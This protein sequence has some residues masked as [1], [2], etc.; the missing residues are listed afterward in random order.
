MVRTKSGKNEVF[1]RKTET[2]VY[3]MSH[4]EEIIPDDVVSIQ[5]FGEA[6][7]LK[8]MRRRISER[9]NIFTYVGNVVLCLNPYMYIPDM[10]RIAEPP[11][12]KQYEYGKDPHVYATA[13]FAYWGLRD[14]DNF[15]ALHAKSRN[16]SCPVSGESGA[17]KTVS[18]GFIMKYLAKLSDWRMAELGLKKD[19]SKPDTTALV[20]GV[21]PF[22]EGFGN[23]KTTM[24]NNSSR[25]GKFTKI[26]FRDGMIKGAEM[27]R[28]L[29]EKGR[30]VEQGVHE[31]NFH[32][33]YGFVK[34]ASAEERKRYKL[35]RVEDYKILMRGNTPTIET[36]SPTYDVDRMNN[37]LSDDPDDTGYRAA[38][39]AAGVG[40]DAQRVLWDCLVA[41]MM[42]GNVNFE[43]DSTR[44]QGMDSSKVSNKKVCDEVERLLGVDDLAEQLVIYRLITQTQTIDKPVSIIGANDNRNALIKALYGHIFQ[45]L[46]VDVASGILKPESKGSEDG[47]IGLLDIFGFE[48]FKRNSME[49]LCINFANEKL[50]KLFND[51][52][53]QT[54]RATYNSQGIPDDCIPPYKDNTPCCHL[55]ERSKDGFMGILPHLNDIRPAETI[56]ENHRKDELYCRDLI[57]MW[58]REPGVNNKCKTKLEKNASKSFFARKNRG[59]KWFVV[60]HFAGDVKYWVDG[61]ITKN[62]DKLPV[63]LDAIMKKSKMAFV[64]NLFR[65]GAKAKGRTISKQFVTDLRR[66]ATTLSHTN[67]HYVRCVKPNN[68]KFRPVDGKAS[69]DAWKTH[70]QLKFAGVMEV[71]KIK[72]E[73]YPFRM[74]YEKFWNDR[75]KRHRYHVFAGV[76]GTLDAKS[77]CEAMCKIIMPPSHKSEVDGKERPTWMSGTTWLFGKDYLPDTFTKWL[78]AK[79]INIVHSCVRYY[80][81]APRLRRAL[82]AQNVLGLAWRRKMKER[83]IHADVRLLVRAY[84]GFHMRARWSDACRRM[85]VWDAV[86]KATMY[87]QQTWRTDRVYRTYVTAIRSLIRVRARR[88]LDKLI[89]EETSRVQKALAVSSVAS[90]LRSSLVML[91]RR[92]RVQYLT[93]AAIA[94]GVFRRQQRVLK[95]QRD[96]AKTAC[97]TWAMSHEI[98]KVRRIHAAATTIQSMA[99]LIIARRLHRHKMSIRT[100]ASAF[101]RMVSRRRRFLQRRQA[102]TTVAQWY[103]WVKIRHKYMLVSDAMQSIRCHIDRGNM[104]LTLK[105]Y[106]R[107]MDQACL[108]GDLKRVRALLTHE[109]KPWRRGAP[110]ETQA[111]YWRLADLVTQRVPY[112]REL[113]RTYPLVNLREPIM[114]STPLHSAVKSGNLGLVELLIKHG[115]DVEA[116]D[117][118]HNTPLHTSC[119]CGDASIEISKLL[120][121]AARDRDHSSEDIKWILG[122]WAENK[123]GRTVL[124]MAAEC[125]EDASNTIS[126][127]IEEDA[128]CSQS[129]DDVL[130]GKLALRRQLE[131]DD[132]ERESRHERVVEAKRRDD[133]IYHFMMIDPRESN[134]DRIVMRMRRERLDK[135][136]KQRAKD[137][138]SAFK[139]HARSVQLA[140]RGFYGHLREKQNATSVEIA[141]RASET[142]RRLEK[143]SAVKRL[144]QKRDKLNEE[145]RAKMMRREEEMHKRYDPSTMK[146]I[147]TFRD[148]LRKRTD[149]HK[150]QTHNVAVE[151]A[152]KAARELAERGFRS[153]LVH[154]DIEDFINDTL[155]ISSLPPQAKATNESHKVENVEGEDF[156]SDPPGMEEERSSISL[157][158]PSSSSG[159]SLQEIGRRMNDVV[160]AQLDRESAEELK[161]E[162]AA[163]KDMEEEATRLMSKIEALRFVRSE[164]ARQRMDGLSKEE[165]EQV[166]WFYRDLDGVVFGPYVGETMHMWTMQGYF[167][168]SLAI[169]LS[170]S[171]PFRRLGDA[172][173][174][175]ENAFSVCP[176]VGF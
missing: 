156:G 33:F 13:H 44:V 167:N 9:F 104:R 86:R 99:R 127:L 87:V 79:V 70:R 101:A 3:D 124:D 164:A 122:R 30:L 141:R 111:K 93:R 153:S 129:V 109:V 154:K 132:R 25:F 137:R 4:D 40:D 140:V 136:R 88:I 49:Q 65:S 159:L 62:Q 144:R 174:A 58:G 133:P 27:V 143:A 1:H 48:V 126:W 92:K 130:E 6:A 175:I 105:R 51:H 2:C 123:E 15:N 84:K 24:N 80:I 73:G 69:F 149:E 32:I 21:S 12:V 45:W 107:E 148:R 117:A 54:E 26:L 116:R 38:L 20:A 90:K 19:P 106:V 147:E 39:R 152:K 102:Q 150:S 36:E 108:G 34:G 46:V 50:Q 94:R 10:V 8:V 171:G 11:H 138:L 151:M 96:A 71:C 68:I 52:I 17:G 97:A 110:A 91:R 78:Q 139:S 165:L 135:M 76:S 121:A 125:G 142:R 103:R 35:K 16:Q 60:K 77:G 75:V 5:G 162:E 161:R 66:L 56:E 59:D 163:A 55:V 61:W 166:E 41:M 72:L 176:R 119:S 31:R 168:D 7:M 173:P 43:V 14:P 98:D 82:Y 145:R 114:W 74:E 37:P 157:P 115:A 113:V 146:K 160:S 22:L 23:A 169:S 128:K 83:Q 81:F 170:E 131:M 57:K 42:L 118:M 64:R 47:F 158:S 134:R 67:P 89:A 53:F 95:A 100:A 18:C 112:K 63:Q 120:H 28:Y 172:F 85:K 29:L 155:D